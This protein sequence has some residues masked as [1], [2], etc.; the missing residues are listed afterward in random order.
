MKKKVIILAI[1]AFT[2]GFFVGSQ[3]AEGVF[4]GAMS[5]WWDYLGS[6][7]NENIQESRAVRH[8]N[9]RESIRAYRQ[10]KVEFAQ[11]KKEEIAEMIRLAPEEYEPS[12]RIVVTESK[13]PNL[14]ITAQDANKNQVQLGSGE[15]LLIPRIIAALPQK[16][17]NSFEQIIIQYGNPSDMRRGMAGGGVMIVKDI[18]SMRRGAKEFISVF[19]HESGHV[20][21]INYLKGNS[22]SP[23]TAFKDGHTPL[24]SDDPSVE[25]YSLNWNDDKTRASN[26]ND[27][28]F[29]SRY[30]MT[31]SFENFAEVFNA[32]ISQAEALR[33]IAS[34]NSVLQKHYDFIK[35]KLYDGGEF[36]AEVDSLQLDQ[37]PR[38]WDTT[39]MPISDLVVDSRI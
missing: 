10:E 20:V 28:N 31:D 3:P 17:L 4:H 14:T 2:Y 23:E 30:A 12:Q 11:K 32:Y 38:V 36:V 5:S 9:I 39:V 22:S 6:Q 19:L 27:L 34:K 37:D 29:P 35:N 21:D 15:A 13:Y 7:T 25:F 16:A 8:N 24:Y 18:A 26:D 33:T 1:L